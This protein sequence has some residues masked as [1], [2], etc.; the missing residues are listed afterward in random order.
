MIVDEDY[1]RGKTEDAR[2][3]YVNVLLSNLCIRPK[4]HAS[5]FN[6][7]QTL[8]SRGPGR[9]DGRNSTSRPNPPPRTSGAPAYRNRASGAPRCTGRTASLAAEG[10]VLRLQVAPQVTGGKV[11]DFAA[12]LRLNEILDMLHIPPALPLG[13]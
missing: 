13:H 11:L 10:R 7:S 6:G 12:I 9:V 2:T 8:L 5:T 3:R 1:A 4:R